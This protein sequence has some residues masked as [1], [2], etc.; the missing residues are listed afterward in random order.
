MFN[1]RAIKAAVA[2]VAIVALG[3]TGVLPTAALIELLDVGVV[4]ELIGG[5]SHEP[6]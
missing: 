1:K 3:S 5:V 2:L 4:P 6:E